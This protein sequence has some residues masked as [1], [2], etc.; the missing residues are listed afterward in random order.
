MRATIICI[1]NRFVPEDAAGMAVFD[2]LQAMRPLPAQVELVEG[3]LAG[4]NLL[5]LLER[6]GRV[7]FVDAV[8]GFAGEGEIVLLT[9]EEICQAKAAPHHDHGAGLAYVLAVLPKVY[10]GE[11]PEEIVLLGLEGRCAVQTV[12]KAAAMAVVIATKGLRGLR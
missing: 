3:G 6:G 2:R 1:G 7:V 8:R 5:P 12:E 11:L 10:D 9:H 4:L